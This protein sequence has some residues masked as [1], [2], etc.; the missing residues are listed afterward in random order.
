MSAVKKINGM[1]E[2]EW[3]DCY[4]VLRAL[5]DGVCPDCGTHGSPEDFEHPVRGKVHLKCPQCGYGLMQ[6]EIERILK[7]SK[8]LLKRRTDAVRKMRALEAGGLGGM[9]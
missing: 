7:L 1:T 3:R 6:D 9:R 2:V 5:H 4:Y 8:V